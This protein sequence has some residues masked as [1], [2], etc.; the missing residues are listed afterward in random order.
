VELGN[1]HGRVQFDN[2]S[3]AYDD[4]LAL[5]CVGLEVPAGQVVALVGPSGAGK[6]TFASLIPRFYDVQEGAVLVEGHD[7]RD[8][9]KSDLREVIAVVSQSPVLF[10]ES[11]M[12]NIRFGKPSASDVEVMEA[13]KKANAHEFIEKTLDNSYQTLVGEKG[14]RLSG[15]QRQRIAI[16]RAFLKDALLRGVQLS[17]LRIVLA[18]LK[19]LNVSLFLK[20]ATL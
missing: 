11:V 2:V 1:V 10:N 15:G 19:L 17:L 4:Q 12:E 6:S 5:E 18:Q 16:A 14:A 20:K 7:V 3:F 13:A 9:R 8:V